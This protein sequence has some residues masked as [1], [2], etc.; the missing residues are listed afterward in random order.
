[1]LQGATD[2]IFKILLGGGLLT[3]FLTV[4]QLALRRRAHVLE[5]YRQAFAMMDGGGL[6]ETRDYI[7][8][9]DER[10]TYET[11]KWLTIE[12][13]ATSPECQMWREHKTTAERVARSFDQLGLLVREGLVPVNVVALFYAW[14]VLRC[15][16]NLAPYLGAV[17]LS[18]NQPGHMWEWENLVFKVIIP[19]L[20]RN[21]GIWKGVSAHNKLES[22]IHDMEHEYKTMVRDSQYA[23]KS[24]VWELS[25]WYKVWK[26]L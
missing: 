1:M 4:Y 5:L 22:L 7:Y 2:V 10:N 8:Y 16:Y 6:N 14:P 26:W 15:W 11:E 18:R 25:P 13:H 24:R 23:P 17:R 12:T 9:L 19:E 21:A 3:L 20:K